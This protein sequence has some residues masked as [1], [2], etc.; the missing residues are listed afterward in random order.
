MIVERLRQRSRKGRETKGENEQNQ[1]RCVKPRI[2]RQIA[3]GQQEADAIRMTRAPSDQTHDK[4]QEAQN[5]ERQRKGTQRRHQE[6]QRI[7]KGRPRA[8]ITHQR[9]ATLLLQ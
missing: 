7:L 8:A 9:D 2:A 4:G 6:E 5:K 1:R 3:R